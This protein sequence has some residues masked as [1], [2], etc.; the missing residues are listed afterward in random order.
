LENKKQKLYLI[1]P[2]T[3]D[4][5]GSEYNYYQNEEK[6]DLPLD[7]VFFDLS[8]DLKESPLSKLIIEE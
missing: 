1:Y 6:N 8:I 5:V 7:V 2:K 4:L 3:A